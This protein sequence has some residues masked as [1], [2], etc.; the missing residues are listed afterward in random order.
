MDD[1]NF[2]NEKLQFS[3]EELAATA[4]KIRQFL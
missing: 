3:K 2:D 1:M 4:E